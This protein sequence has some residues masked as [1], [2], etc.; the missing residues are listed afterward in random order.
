MTLAQEIRQLAAQ[1]QGAKQPP[2]PEVKDWTATAQRIEAEIEELMQRYDAATARPEPET[3]N[4]EQ[5]LKVI[6]K[7]V[8][9]EL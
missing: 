5:R 3:G 9:A 2:P 8:V 4:R 6:L 7:L 1:I